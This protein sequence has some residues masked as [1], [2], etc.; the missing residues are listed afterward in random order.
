MA[1]S[2]ST[3]DQERLFSL[4][5]G[6]AGT[7]NPAPD[8]GDDPGL[9]GKRLGLINGSAWIT[10]WSYYFGR[11]HLPGVKLI[12]VGNEAVQ[13][14]FME[15]HARGASGPPQA[16][17]ECFSRYARDLV[18]LGNVDAILITCSTMNRSFAR[19]R[20]SVADTGI[21]VFQIDEPMMRR[22]LKIGGKLLIVATHGPTCRSTMKLLHETAEELCLPRPDC[23]M[24]SIDNAF[25]LL[26][27]EG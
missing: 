15:A 12:N 2:Y 9:A 25:E 17:I 1:T 7:P 24:A 11:K 23:R 22:A 26:G 19:V 4:F 8:A 13:L 14:N 16:N 21:P 20:E 3:L 18:E 5:M 10:L 27:I 6:L